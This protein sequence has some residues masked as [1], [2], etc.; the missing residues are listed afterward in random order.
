MC[1]PKHPCEDWV[2]PAWTG[3]TFCR[4]KGIWGLPWQA[5]VLGIPRSELH[6]PLTA[7][8]DSILM[9]FVPRPVS[10]V[11]SPLE[12]GFTLVWV[13]HATV[14]KMVRYTSSVARLFSA[15]DVIPLGEGLWAMDLALAQCSFPWQRE[16]GLCHRRRGRNCP[17]MPQGLGKVTEVLFRDSFC[18]QRI[19][20]VR[21]L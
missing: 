18:R 19:K 12:A 5:W 2:S 20:E 17:Q 8:Q 11:G 7:S 21:F 9:L 14:E 6:V 3:E 13:L 4:D 16:D 15:G 10:M 1:T